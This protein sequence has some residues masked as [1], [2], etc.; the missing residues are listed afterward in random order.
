M[1]KFR[2]AF[3]CVLAAVLA[4]CGGD[5]AFHG[6]TGSIGGT[7]DPAATSV[8]VSSNDATIPA[9]GSASATISAL[10]RD[11]NN[12]AVPNATVSFG[13][14]A[15]AVAITSA[16]TDASGTATA[17]LSASG[18][19]AGTQITV[20]A[21]VGSVS[22]KTTVNV[23]A[24]QQAITLLTS[25][26][27]M[28]S[29]NSKPA[30]ITAVVQGA[31]NQL[32]A[33]VPVTFSASSGAIVAQQTTA[34]ATSGV[35][36]GTT[37]ANGQAQA[38]LSTPG[39]ATNRNIT[40]TATLGSGNVS[41]TVAVAVIGTKLTVTG[42]TSL[43][44]G[45]SGTFNVSLT[46][47]ASNGIGGQ[48]VTLASANGNTLS[49]PT[50]QTDSTGHATFNVTAA[51]PGNDTITATAMGLSTTQAVAVS[52]QNFT[53][54][55]PAQN[56][57]VP[58]SAAQVVTLVWKNGGAP[59][60]N[61]TVTFST[62]RGL[63]SNNMTTVAATTDAT[64]TAQASLSSTTAGPAVVSATAT[65]V[66]A[67]LSLTFVATTPASIDL[68]ANPATIQTQ[69]QSTFTATVRDAQNNLVQ[70]Q[71]V[72]FQ[73]TDQTGGSI[74]VA[75][76]VT[77]PQGQAQTVYTAT[78]TAS[79]ANGVQV[80]ATVQG[81]A[82]SKSATLT[83][84]GQTVFLSLG[85]GNQIQQLPA[86]CGQGAPCTEFSVPYTVQALDSRG[87]PVPGANVALTV[88]SLPLPPIPPAAQPP[89]GYNPPVAPNYTTTSVYGAY[90]KGL[91]VWDTNITPNQWVQTAPPVASPIPSPVPS[92]TYCQNEDVD[93]TGIY[94]NSEDINGNGKLD[95]GDV[96]TV[97]PGTITTDSTG[98]GTVNVIYPQDHAWWVQVILIAT[99]TVNGTQ[100]STN[101]VF[102]LPI[103][104]SDITSQTPPPPGQTSPYGTATS[105]AD[106]N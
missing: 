61:Q 25:S 89:P 29:D 12:V 91:W 103:L 22:G 65:G 93:A 36:A 18:A 100:A 67:Q 42:P 9:D 92:P 43:I 39:N 102:W 96:A 63:F 88:H 49:A 83:V 57:N 52:S 15:G 101:T 56:T 76:A 4:A 79:T 24:T 14:S 10:V 40:V 17:L 73:L 19:A 47:S 26:T 2:T 58:I 99:S 72:D 50:V 74:S 13:A 68:Q 70:G 35:A 78:T 16:T 27:Q 28:P 46:D 54:T 20:T 21:A 44:M 48:T 94:S 41:A 62:T 81:T 90:A 71:T 77:D 45:S 64:G 32:L 33:N 1:R 95:P 38:V 8:M 7:G 37:D 5:N 53:F 60:A 30:T 105:C 80:T 87:N 82:I 34:G 3:L 106:P 11:A 97:S 69:G 84:G 66:S 23:V 85:T 75:T 31:S 98:S 59:Q 104:A 6:T 51:V 55:A 86:G